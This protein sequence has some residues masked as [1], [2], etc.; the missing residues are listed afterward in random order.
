MKKLLAMSLIVGLGF[1]AA[2]ANA[3]Y[4]STS[5][6][7]DLPTESYKTA[8]PMKVKYSIIYTN[9]FEPDSNAEY[10]PE[11]D[12]YG[13]Y[14]FDYVVLN[15]KPSKSFPLDQVFV[16]TD[17]IDMLKLN[18]AEIVKKVKSGPKGKAYSC[19]IQGEMNAQFNMEY[20]GR[21]FFRF[22]T[23]VSGEVKSAT[24]IGKSKVT[25]ETY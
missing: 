2:T 15:K 8:K 22:V 6:K 17:L 9:E 19:T 24:P 11:P 7:V 12:K 3:Q 16:Y 23:S 4:V 13:L 20:D 21:N 10:F 1:T 5:K 25:C 18:R 14:Q